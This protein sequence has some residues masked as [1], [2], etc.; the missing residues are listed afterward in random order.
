MQCSMAIKR[1]LVV[2]GD[3]FLATA[4]LLSLASGSTW[5]QGSPE[6]ARAIMAPPA[7][8]LDAAPAVVELP[9]VIVTGAPTRAV[10]GPPPPA[11]PGGQVG[12]GTRVGLLGNQ[13]VFNTPFSSTGY[14][15]KLIR[16]QQART[17]TD[18]AAND[19]SVRSILQR[20]SFSDQFFIRGFGFFPFDI[21][22]DGLY[23]LVDIRRPAVEGIERVEILKGPTTFLNGV[24]P[25]GG[26]V[27]GTIT[28][29]PKRATED[30]ITRVNIG[31]VGRSE[32]GTSV[33][34]SRRY[35]ANKEWGIRFNGAYRAGNSAVDRSSVKFGTASLGLDYRGERVR[36]SLDLGY[37]DEKVDGVTQQRTVLPGFAI[38]TAPSGRSNPAQ[39]WEYFDH[40]NAFA[41]LRAEYDVTDDVTVYAAYGASRYREQSLFGAPSIINRFGDTLETAN[42]GSG[43]YDNQ[44]VDV[45]VR[46][47][48]EIG[49]LTHRLSLS[50][51]VVDRPFESFNA[52]AITGVRSNIYNPVF[53]ARPFFANPGFRPSSLSITRSIALGDTISALNDRVS[54]TL[55][56]RM[57]QIAAKNYDRSG[58]TTSSYKDSAFTPAV[59]LVVK[60]LRDL[61]L[62]GNYVESLQQ[63][64][65][66]PMTAVNTG[67]VFPAFVAKQ[68]EIGAKYDFGSTGLGLAAFDI[69]QPSSF[70]DPATQRFA[71]DGLQRNRGL[72][73]TVFGEPAKGVR[74][75]G[76]VTLLEGKLE[77]TV[78]GL[79]D[80]KTAPGVPKLQL[81]MYGEYDVPFTWSEGLTVTGRVI[82]TSG[83]FYDQ[84][85][86]QSIAGWTRFDVGARY[87][88]ERTAGKPIVIRAAIENVADRGYWAATGRG[89]LVPGAPRTYLLSTS[90]DF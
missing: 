25:I 70:T 63:G 46:A 23:G 13:S 44:T 34:V 24:P 22:F 45:G 37:Q 75:L 82:H 40:N 73:F 58:A 28:L 49:P 21:G 47:R 33:D 9:Q 52:T 48:V 20:A 6:G 59:G 32:V 56:G 43:S 42:A 64:S 83:Q 67:E 77:R 36:L 60:P 12:S 66:A 14:T 51:I 79:T 76:G 74:L 62:Y 84:A 11:F 78:G 39:P 88:R 8:R 1:G 41:A 87:T 86:T 85:N 81:N 29:I 18:V 68:Y 57:Q 89:F 30:P 3:V 26:G 69:A 7:V 27:G 4:A 35:G 50:G 72:E 53:V 10:I 54:L 61:S 17:I 15:D 31:V 19:P 38:P 65:V 16:D 5:A 55:G 90:F 2:R 71:V 80:G